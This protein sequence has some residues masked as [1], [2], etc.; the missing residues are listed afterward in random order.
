MRRCV[1]L[2]RRIRCRAL[3]SIDLTRQVLNAVADTLLTPLCAYDRDHG[4]DL[5]LPAPSW[6]PTV[7]GNRRVNIGADRHTLRKR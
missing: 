7:I 5:V 1:P 4:T 3:L 6:K 2:D